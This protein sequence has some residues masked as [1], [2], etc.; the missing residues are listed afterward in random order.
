MKLLNYF[1]QLKKIIVLPKQSLFEGISNPIYYSYHKKIFFKFLLCGLFKNEFQIKF[2]SD[3][4][5]HVP[6][7]IFSLLAYFEDVLEYR[8]TM[9]YYNKIKKE[10]VM[11][12]K[13]FK[14][15]SPILTATHLPVNEFILEDVANQMGFKIVDEKFTALTSIYTLAL[16]SD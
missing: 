7:Y 12:L 8:L 3:Y 10:T 11:F 13:P 16:S 14:P 6:K 15:L 4:W 5:M 9:F 2:G 1:R